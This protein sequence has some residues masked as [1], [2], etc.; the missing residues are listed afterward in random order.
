VPD[1]LVT[2]VLWHAARIIAD[3]KPMA[4][5][6]FIRFNLEIMFNTTIPKRQWYMQV[7]F[8][9]VKKKAVIKRLF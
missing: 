4:A 7:N 8:E 2:G 9:F 3:E 1:A 5:L 6:F